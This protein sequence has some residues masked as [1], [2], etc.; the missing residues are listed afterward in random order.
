[1]SDPSAR[2]DRFI[3]ASDLD[4]TLIDPEQPDDPKLEAFARAL[5]GAGGRLA[6]WFNSSRPVRSQRESLAGVRH[7]PR[8][9][10]LIGAMGTEIQEGK[11][12]QM[13]E[14][15]GREQ[16][17]DWP[18]EEI[19]ALVRGKFGLVPHPPHLQTRFK[20]SYDLPDPS[21]VADIRR[22]LDG[23]GLDSRVV[24]SGGRDLDLLPPAAGKAAAIKW[25]CDLTGM[26]HDAVV[27][28]GDS[29][30]DL[31]M[32]EPPFRGIAVAN[33]H[34]ELKRLSGPGI[35]QAKRRCAAGVLE[36]LR[37]FGVLPRFEQEDQV[38]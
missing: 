3:L 15:Y 28:S 23:Q 30:N 33:A 22:N 7:L 37:H 17:G 18:R 27:V 11:S 24:F 9:E 4:G 1:M 25:L 21:L 13:V 36:G 6:L 32:F 10:Y 29:A 26:P 38:Q 12:G 5:A 14:A 20:A 16:F 35:F 34:D 2:L 19:D 31:D 8:P